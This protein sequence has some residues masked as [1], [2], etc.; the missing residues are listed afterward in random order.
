MTGH[1]PH[2]VH[3][4]SADFIRALGPVTKQGLALSQLDASKIREG[5]AAA[6]GMS[7]AELA[8]QLS[9]AQRAKSQA[10]IDAETTRLIQAMQSH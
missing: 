9:K 10:D 5:I 2:N 7:D 6:I 1:T 8:H 4:D 3:A